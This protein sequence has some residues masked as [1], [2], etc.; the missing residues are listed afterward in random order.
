[1]VTKT[2]TIIGYALGALAIGYAATTVKSVPEKL[3]IP[4]T[5]EDRMIVP[6]ET[7]GLQ[8]LGFSTNDKYNIE[9]NKVTAYKPLEKV[10]PDIKD[11]MELEGK[12]VDKSVPITALESYLSGKYNPGL[13]YISR[14]GTEVVLPVKIVNQ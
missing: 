13:G 2:S 7:G 14:E 5:I 8:V 12:L 10:Y 9:L 1:M 3:V 6:Y 4:Q 11:E